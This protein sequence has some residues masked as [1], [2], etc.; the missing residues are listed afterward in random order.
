MAF[1]SFFK[2]KKYPIVLKRDSHSISPGMVDPGALFVMR[3]L[4]QSG[5][6]AYLVGGCVRDIL[7]GRNPK[8]FDVTT[9]AR[10]NQVKR[11]FRKCFL[12]GRRFRLAHVYTGTDEFIEVATFRALVDAEEEGISKVAANNVFGTIEEDALRRDFTI[13]ALYLNSADLSVVDFTGGLR[14]IKKKL[15]RSIGDPVQRFSDDPV[16]M[17]RLARFCAMLGFSPSREDHR[18]A[19]L[20]AHHIKDANANRMLDEMYK[21][22]KCGASA[23]TFARLWE[24]GVLQHWIP[25]LAPERYRDPL[26]KRLAVIDE[27]RARGEEIPGNVIIAALFY[28][29]FSGAEG[30]SGSLQDAL[31]A[32]HKRHHELAVRLRFP[33]VE[34]E[35]VCN[36]VARQ[37]VFTRPEGGKKWGQ[38]RAKFVRNAYFPDALTFFEI[39]VKATGRDESELRAWWRQT[40]EGERSAHGDI[41]S[42]SDRTPSR[43]RGRGP[44]DGEPRTDHTAPAED[45]AI[46]HNVDATPIDGQAADS[47]TGA[48][49]KKRRRRGGKRRRGGPRPEAQPA[50]L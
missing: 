27:R 39:M 11:L 49:K 8:D 13:N 24:F 50:S 26:M 40:P 42:R 1:L 29:V 9:D 6:E 23:G 43:R 17:V 32:I 31:H 5:F 19:R 28:D 2:K 3:R 48:P 22:F 21:I 18:A 47:G 38:F 46:A 4:R 41:R 14:D 45:N 15:L 33:R 35:K 30:A 37:T 10:P 12:I 36:T 34:W 20:L 16:R 25:E 7:L 44:R